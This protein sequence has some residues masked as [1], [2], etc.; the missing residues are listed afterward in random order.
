MPLPLRIRNWPLRT[1]LLAVIMAT[2]AV[3]LLLAGV[4]IIV[5]DAILFNRYLERDLTALAQIT[6]DNS[7]GA[8]AFDD[9]TAASET[10]SALKARTHLV[11]ACI[12]RADKTVLAKYSRTGATLPCPPQEAKRGIDFQALG[13]SAVKPVLLAEQPIGTLTLLYD[14]G[15]TG[16]SHCGP[17]LHTAPRHHRRSRLWPRPNRHLGLGQPQLRS[18]R[19][20]G[21]Q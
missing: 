8:L 7:T 2:V 19:G 3:A 13:V 1:K 18:S 21:L 9:P 5:S 4:G 15:E 20:K 6:A 11:A 17:C 14:Y 16:E 12:Y 10:L